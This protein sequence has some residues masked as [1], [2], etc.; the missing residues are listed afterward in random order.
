MRNSRRVV[1]FFA[2]LASALAP[3]LLSAQVVGA[4]L[5]GV[6]T[7]VSHAGIPQLTVTVRNKENGSE[8]RLLKDNSGRYSSPSITIGAY[9]L[10]ASKSGFASQQ[11]SGVSLVVGESSTV[12]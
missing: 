12:D 7:D 4:S 8:R 6:V 1:T 11:K 10:T 9:V 5:S 3:G 2:L